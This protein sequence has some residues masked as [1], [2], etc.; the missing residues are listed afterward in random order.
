MTDIEAIRTVLRV[1]GLSAESSREEVERVL[2]A[3][4]YT[5]DDVGLV[6]GA[7]PTPGVP[8]QS[9]S[10]TPPQPVVVQTAPIASQPREQRV[11]GSV[12]VLRRVVVA[13][14]VFCALVLLVGA[15][16]MRQYPNLVLILKGYEGS[17]QIIAAFMMQVFLPACG[18][19]IAIL[20][21]ALYV[22]RRTNVTQTL[23]GWLSV[24]LSWY[25]AIWFLVV[26]ALLYVVSLYARGNVPDWMS[27]GF[28]MIMSFGLT[29]TSFAFVAVTVVAI[30]LGLLTYIKRPAVHTTR[31]CKG[32][33][34]VVVVSAIASLTYY[35][36]IMRYP[37]EFFNARILCY[38]T[39]GASY[40]QGCLN[41][42]V[43]VRANSD[44]L[45]VIE[46]QYVQY[47]SK[48]S[49]VFLGD[50]LVFVGKRINDVSGGPSL[51]R[52]G[53]EEVLPDGVI[54][55][56][57]IVID[58][59]LV[60]LGF[61]KAGDR[62]KGLLYVD[63]VRDTSYDDAGVIASVHGKLAIFE[64]RGDE[65]RIVWDGKIFVLPPGQGVSDGTVRIQ[66]V[67][68]A[69]IAYTY[70]DAQKLRHVLVDGKE[71]LP[72]FVGSLW[73]FTSVNGQLA[74]VYEVVERGV[75][76]TEG[77]VQVGAE[78]YPIKGVV[79][80]AVTL[81][82]G[83]AVLVGQRDKAILVPEP[84]ANRTIGGSFASVPS[85]ITDAELWK[86]LAIEYK[87]VRYTGYDRISVPQS[88]NGKLAFATQQGNDIVV[89]VAGAEYARFPRQ[90]NLIGFETSAGG[91]WLVTMQ[92]DQ[93]NLSL[94]VD[95]KHSDGTV[96]QA[97]FFGEHLFTSQKNGQ[98]IEVFADGVRLGAGLRVVHPK[99]FD[100]KMLSFAADI[101]SNRGFIIAD[102]GL[103]PVDTRDRLR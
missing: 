55:Q 3:A 27:F 52:A 64:S 101:Q 23:G 30:V 84:A 34:I 90:G 28:K 60:Y 93:S 50:D 87:G 83:I 48:D 22:A 5:I 42:S 29:F 25:I 17:P 85:L 91:R 88:L 76:V 57:L 102:K 9:I 31:I 77:H 53:K 66:E 81:E 70:T 45:D 26:H 51:I 74:L 41:A 72:P 44:S 75:G 95:G 39:A 54:P 73:E 63:G 68:N 4:G 56:E 6:S 100:G 19:S 15:Y 47:G 61:N 98:T 99:V 65:N 46:T 96:L 2:L 8:P 35:A 13:W 40:Q 79:R 89:Y 71:V 33:T 92:D 49:A 67:G 12:G 78:Q 43:D 36:G 21:L 10:A 97:A 32:I 58:G 24:L 38:A 82:D 103:I 69:S 7:T 20:L 80:S 11:L 18:F 59:K 62:Y 94:Y 14:V 1:N 16:A 86:T 37:A